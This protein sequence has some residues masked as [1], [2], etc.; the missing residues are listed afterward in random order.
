MDVLLAIESLKSTKSSMKATAN[1]NAFVLKE[2]TENVNRGVTYISMKSNMRIVI[3]V[4][5]LM[6]RVVQFLFVMKEMRKT[7]RTIRTLNP[8][9]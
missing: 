5:H 9:V 7:Y 2:V 8:L 4:H 3:G 1:I 6:T